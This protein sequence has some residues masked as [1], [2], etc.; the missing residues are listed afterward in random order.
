MLLFMESLQVSQEYRTLT[1][2]PNTTWVPGGEL[3]FNSGF[4]FSDESRGENGTISTMGCLSQGTII[5]RGEST[6]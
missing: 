6:C 3:W 1:E 4:Y 2:T 5:F